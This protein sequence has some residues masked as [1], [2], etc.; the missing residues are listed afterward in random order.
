MTI[1]VESMSP[2]NE[3]LRLY[4]GISSSGKNNLKLNRT[5]ST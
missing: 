1:V 4:R 2:E 5:Q 3:K